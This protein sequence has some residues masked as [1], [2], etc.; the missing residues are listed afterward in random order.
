MSSPSGRHLL[1]GW[2]HTRLTELL[3]VRYP[4][5]QAPMA[6]ISTAPLV[7]AVSESGALGSLGSALLRSC[8]LEGH[9]ERVREHTE[10]PFAVNFY[11]HQAP[12][13]DRVALARMRERLEPYRRELDAGELGVGDLPPEP[14][15]FDS[16]MLEQVLALRP[17]VVSF[18]FGCPERRA[19]EA[20]S[21]AGILTVGTATT[22]TEAKALEAFG[23]DL[24][25]AQ[26]IEAGGH[27]GT[28]ASSY[29]EGQLG[30]LALVPQI[31]DAVSVPVI[32]T[33]GIAD[34]RGIAAALALGA[35]GVQLGT[36]FL[37][38]PE[39]QIETLYRRTL[40]GPRAAHTQIT[41]AL[42]GRP[43]RA[44]SNRFIREMASEEGRVLDFPLQR[45]LTAVLAQAAMMRGDLEF[46]AMWAGQGAPLIRVL[47]AAELVA[48]LVR[49]TEQALEGWKR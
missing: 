17:A 4:I 22:V 35:S 34:G 36:A 15:P 19:H 5:I 16:A 13:I 25:V 21:S 45:Q 30:T 9:V 10:R 27:R 28:F 41:S 42:W 11:V 48:T 44:I 49:E 2:A 24:I 14:R 40:F 39:A 3:G 12:R 20:L 8:E 23:M 29:P 38:C 43:A 26:G 47:P 32:A 1:R 46:A 6:S 37:G 31:V 18:L 33:G 7:S